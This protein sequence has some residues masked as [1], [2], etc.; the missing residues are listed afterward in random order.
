MSGTVFIKIRVTSAKSGVYD[1]GDDA[2]LSLFTKCSSG[3]CHAWHKEKCHKVFRLYCSH[4]F[5]ASLQ[6]TQVSDKSCAHIRLLYG[7]DALCDDVRSFLVDEYRAHQCSKEVAARY[8]EGQ[9]AFDVG[10]GF[11]R[12][13]S[14]SKDKVDEGQ[15]GTYVS[16]DMQLCMVCI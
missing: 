13:P 10:T 4:L 2:Q 11:Y 1:D 5:T 7:T 3:L 16:H 6:Q 15:L 12:F 9:V 8:L 14:L